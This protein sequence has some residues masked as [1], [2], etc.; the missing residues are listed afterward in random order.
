MGDVI[1]VAGAPVT[2]SSIVMA[3][4]LDAN[5]GAAGSHE[6][7]GAVWRLPGCAL[8]PVEVVG[9]RGHARRT[10]SDAVIVHEP[11]LLL[12]HHVV[13]VDNVPVTTPTRTLFD[14][15]GARTV[16]PKRLERMLDTAWSRNLVS[17]ASLT[18][19]LDELAQ[20]GRPG[21][22][23]MRELLA[24][25]PADH[26]PPESS[27][28]AR[29]QELARRSGLYSFVRQC[30][31]GDD[32]AWIGR[33]DFIDLNRRLVVEVVDALF[34]GSLTDQ[35]HDQE[36]WQRLTQSGLR[37]EAVDGF[38]LFHRPESV[39]ARLRR[40]AHRTGG[41]PSGEARSVPTRTTWL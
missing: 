41:S 33:V 15:A 27:T 39:M 11:K 31:M 38:D 10:A 6:T 26:R 1:R 40:L 16:H 29:F 21:I 18:R 9:R 28:E 3:A 5:V 14:L 32:A 2:R 20:R 8:E 34:H 4:V 36:R 13:E 37:V 24:D 22:R 19:M 7:S 23:L 25:R 17:H 30:D 35:R 12:P